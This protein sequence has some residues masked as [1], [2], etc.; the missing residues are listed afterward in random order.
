M[1]RRCPCRAGRRSAAALFLLLPALLVSIPA[2]AAAQTP[3]PVLTMEQAIEAALAGHPDVAAA[4][5]GIAAAAARRRQ[6]EARPDPRLALGAGGLPFGMKSRAGQESEIELGLEGTIEISGKRAARIE[7]GRFEEDAAVLELE[8]VRLV[9]AAKVRRAY[10]RTACADE[11]LARI[12]RAAQ[13]L[14]QAAE[15]IQTQY[16][17]GRAAYADVLR[18]R[19]DKARL[20]GRV[21]EERRERRAS[22]A[23]LGALIGRTSG[24][25]LRL[26]PGLP[27]PKPLGTA[28]EIKSTALAA[29][30]SI[31]IAGLRA[32]QAAAAERL[33]GLNRRPDL[34]AGI[35]LPSKRLAAW[36]FSLGLTLPFSS[37]RWSGERAEA[38]AARAAELAAVDGLK[39]RLAAEIEAAYE[40]VLLADEQARIFEDRLLTEIEDELKVSLDLYALGRLEA[41]ALLDLHRAAVEARLEHL[42]ALCRRALSR[43]DLDAAGE[44]IL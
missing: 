14:D 13:L 32:E 21:A 17:A 31:R 27:V 9:L 8:R 26:S 34:E 28:E 3:P 1:S 24:D 42:R 44:D 16:A 41:Y 6:A 37:K 43:I 4:Q 2:A 5:A 12:A 38:A 29:R 33:A 35:Y 40:S 10:I 22:A 15:A 23:E 7:V 30:P 36:G 39:R 25:E 18:A 11:A 20:M 19:V